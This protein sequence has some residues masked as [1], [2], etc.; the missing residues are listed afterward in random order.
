MK[1]IIL[2]FYFFV[3]CNWLFAQNQNISKSNVFKANLYSENLSIDKIP[4]EIYIKKYVEDKISEWQ[5]KG[6]FEKTEDYQNRVNE[7]SR[8]K[9]AQI[10]TNE[11]VNQKKKQYAAN[12]S[13]NNLTLS[14]YNTENETYLLQSTELG[15][16]PISVPMGE[17]ANFKQNFNY[18]IYKDQDY[19]VNNNKLMLAKLNIETIEGKIYNFDNQKA[20]TYSA[21][22]ITFNF[23][24]INVEINNNNINLYDSVDV[25][26]N[27]P[28]NSQ[29][30]DKTFVVIIANENYQKEVKVQFA[31]NDGKVFKDYCEKT[32]GIP[33][34]NIHFTKD[35]TFGNM[36][37]EIKWI[38]DVSLAFNEETKLIFYYTGHGM[39]NETN[40]S[41]YLLA[42]D[43]SSS[44]FETAIKLEDLYGKLTLNPSKN[45]T[46]FLDACFNGAFRD[47]DVWVNNRSVRIKPKI[48][49]EKGI[50]LFLQQLQ[51]TKQHILTKK[52]NMD[53][54]HI[55]C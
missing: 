50:W 51:A 26:I 3:V 54:L 8:S 45:V 1:S 12:I 36:K 53:C 37:S 17:A 39:T 47:D 34:K 6:E 24:P 2:L 21:E 23:K 42:V 25:D 29:T 5:Q 11:A 35:A 19:Y 20:T 4:I 28:V 7:N 44:D 43:G 14:N 9:Q 52:N 40:K 46:V 13:W 49:V 33:A 55:F 38:S 22:N 30:N 10:Y 41:A 31:T 27:I 15:D 32:L 48:D 18:L 16:I